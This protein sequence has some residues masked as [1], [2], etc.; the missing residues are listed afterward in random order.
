VAVGFTSSLLNRSY[1]LDSTCYWDY[2]ADCLAG[3][4][5][6]NQALVQY[7]DIKSSIKS[8]KIEWGNSNKEE[9]L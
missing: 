2:L 3:A 1:P 5:P 4:A 6:K 7:P 9:I 8:K